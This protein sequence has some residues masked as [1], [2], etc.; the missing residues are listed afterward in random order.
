MQIGGQMPK[1]KYRLVTSE[2]IEWSSYVG[3]AWDNVSIKISKV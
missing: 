3:K 2:G 1:K